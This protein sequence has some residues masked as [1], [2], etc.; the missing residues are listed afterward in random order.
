MGEIPCLAKELFRSL[1]RWS[2][3][4]SSRTTGDSTRGLGRL[5][6][7]WESAAGDKLFF[8]FFLSGRTQSTVDSPAFLR[9]I[10]D[11][12]SDLS[13]RPGLR[14]QVGQLL[15]LSCPQ[16][17]SRDDG[18]GRSQLVL[19]LL[20]PLPSLRTVTISTKTPSTHYETQ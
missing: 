16:L 2:L 7:P 1:V 3:C 11:L 12:V 9:G 6:N 10:P 19:L 4:Y 14:R 20:I 15:L 18:R 13:W 17:L 5:Q 8:F